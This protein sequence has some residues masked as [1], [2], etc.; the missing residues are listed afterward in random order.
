MIKKEAYQSASQIADELRNRGVYI[1]P[2]SSSPLAELVELSSDVVE[3]NTTNLPSILIDPRMQNRSSVSV[4][5][6]AWTVEAVTGNNPDPSQHSL[7]IAALVDDLAPI[8]TAHISMARNTVVPLVVELTG[9]MQ[10]FLETTDPIDPAAQFRI[11][12]CALP[13]LLGDESFMAEGLE[14]YHNINAPFASFNI[15]M[16]PVENE[17]FY[18]G[19]LN[20]SNDRLN[21]KLAR[22]LQNFDKDF[23]KNVYQMNFGL[24]MVKMPEGRF[25]LSEPGPYV[26]PY[27]AADIALV[28][29][30]MGQ[31]LM[32]NVQSAEGVT[33]AKY[34]SELRSVIDFAGTIIHKCMRTIQRQ[35]E[36]NMM[37]SRVS[38]SERLIVVN[39]AIYQSWI[40]SGG[41][42]EALLGMVASGDVVYSVA[43]IEEKKDALCRQW[44]NFVTLAQTDI[45]EERRRRFAQYVES[46][47]L[48]GMND[49]TEV[50]KAYLVDHP[51]HIERVTANIREEL[52]HFNHRL[53]DD[54]PHLALHLIAKARFYFTSS[55]L[56]LREMAEVAKVNADVDPR[57]A[58]LLATITYITEYMLGQ[59]KFVR[60]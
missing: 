4:E 10:K 53:M 39:G 16:K 36:A 1:V 3:T 19:L 43:A 35:F 37:V 7:K 30:I 5:E 48:I 49:L 40:E 34:K 58:A 55:Y 8:V 60:A 29:Y 6:R 54:L 9:K 27:T 2:M 14:T 21:E 44:A 46:E 51:G 59:M 24:D 20:L 13:S 11:K 25:A 12:K 15:K 31:N 41:C 45:N 50:E 56:I 38:L 32:A 57:E 26:D 28:V 42:P 33:L 47:T 18:Y 23:V 52:M 22:W 17:D